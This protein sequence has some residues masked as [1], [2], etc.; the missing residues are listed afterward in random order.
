MD[1]LI[2]CLTSLASGYDVLNGL[3]ADPQS[4]KISIVDWNKYL[5][6][7]SGWSDTIHLREVL[8]AECQWKDLQHPRVG[9]V[10]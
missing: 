9:H 5:S 8:P 6:V 1:N 7:I 3:Y 10:P 4:C 2:P